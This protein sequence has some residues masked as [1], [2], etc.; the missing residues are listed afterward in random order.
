MKSIP[1]IES[2]YYSSSVPGPPDPD[3]LNFL[4][5]TGITDPTQ[6]AAISFIIP[7]LK[8]SNTSKNPNGIDFW[9]Q[10]DA[11]HP[12]V[13]GT[14]FTNKFN[15]KDP[16][17]L[18]AAF[19]LN[20]SGGWT[21]SVTGSKGNGSNTYA[22][23]FWIPNTRVSV[24]SLSFGHYLRVNS[25]VPTQ[26]LGV[27]SGANR[28]QHYIEAGTLIGGDGLTITFTPS[29]VG[30]FFY[31][32]TSNSFARG[33]KNTGTLGT[34]LTTVSQLPTHK[35]FYGALNNGGSGY[36][37]PSVNEYC[38]GLL[39]AQSFNDAEATVL[40]NIINE[41][42]IML[43]R[44]TYGGPLNPVT[45]PD[46]QPIVWDQLVQS[47]NAGSGTLTFNNATLPNGGSSAKK[48]GDVNSYVEF[49]MPPTIAQSGN[50]ALMV[51]SLDDANYGWLSSPTFKVALYYDGTSYSYSIN[52]SI[53]PIALSGT[54]AVGDI[55]RIERT[56][57][58]DLS[59]KLS[60]NAGAS[61]STL[62]TLTNI[63][64]GVDYPYIKGVNLLQGASKRSHL[65]TG[66]K[67]RNK[68]LNL[69]NNE[70]PL[71]IFAGE[72]NSGGRV[73]NA[74]ATAGELLPNPN[75]QII[76]NNNLLL[77][78]LDIGTNNL[79]G[80][81][82]LSTVEHSWEL[83]LANNSA[84]GYLGYLP[85]YLVKT[86]QG[87]AQI[88]NLVNGGNYLGVNS[89]QLFKDRVDAAIAQIQVLYPAKTIVPMVFMSIGINDGILGN[90]PVTWRTAVE[91]YISD[92]RA[93][94]GAT[95]PVIMTKIP[96]T[97]A[98]FN[99]QIDNITAA[100][101]RV[102]SVVTSDASMLDA[103][104]WDYAGQKLISNR[105]QMAVASLV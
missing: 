10:A 102:L 40:A 45:P 35:V 24:N 59:I 31:T 41:F 49:T 19:R 99:A 47:V 98:T 65:A 78:D 72:S 71:F 29:S 80:H 36:L 12:F 84:S 28:V 60:V 83:Q 87:G 58:D 1:K 27:V 26:V 8:G 14:A 57:V 15:L 73:P 92:I 46:I 61:F 34:L 74:S 48:L 23:T 18:D 13:G 63:L 70:V 5:A 96:A 79:L 37:Y 54:P 76:N 52:D 100:D 16:R 3:V 91:G 77:E 51:S 89:W 67:L 4:T 25:L 30:F 43:N 66:Y 39:T 9:T 85:A 50:V 75:V 64:S 94:Y 69:D 21:H 44:H 2:Y 95:I 6:V 86:G 55:L 82:G 103:N 88:A 53:T 22:D 7:S 17:D 68:I 101:N 38:F 81:T 33:Y 104:H 93:R 20:F 32:R 42:Q 105:M 56:S 90:N 62:A 97:Y 11:F